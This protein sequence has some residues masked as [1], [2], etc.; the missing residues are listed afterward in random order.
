M[1]LRKDA[2]KVAS[3]EILDQVIALNEPRLRRLIRDYV[4]YYHKDQIHC[5][6]GK[7]TPNGRPNRT[8]AVLASH[9]NLVR[10]LG[11]DCIIGIPGKRQHK[12]CCC[13]IE[14]DQETAR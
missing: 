11:P 4:N 13:P 12:E 1:E 14:I 7:D 3:R 8:K 9:G 2:W 6:L 10:A 5:S